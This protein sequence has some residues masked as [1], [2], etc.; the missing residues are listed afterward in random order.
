MNLMILGAGA[1]GCLFGAYLSTSME[2]T[3]VDPNEEKLG[4]LRREGVTVLE[5]GGEETR[6]APRCLTPAEAARER[7]N[8]I[9]VF[10]KSARERRALE[11]IR[12]AMGPE[13]VLMTLQNGMGHEEAML[14][15]APAEQIIIG[16]T[17][18]NAS[19]LSPGVVRHGGGGDT[20]LGVLTGEA[21]RFQPIA[22]LFTA[23]GLETAVSEN[24][25]G[26]IWRKLFLNASGS[27]LTAVYDCPLGAVAEGERWHRCERLIRESVAVAR[28][29]G[30]PFD[31]KEIIAEIHA[32]ILASPEAR[33]SI[34]ADLK[35][36]RRTE[37]DAITGAVVRLGRKYGVPVPE[38]E[39]VVNTIHE[40]EGR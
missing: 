2:V 22:D 16:A 35:A 5:P 14:A 4:L 29:D 12:G 7:G 19:L 40:L 8:L 24:V 38:S 28:A 6:A 1:M 31:E 39:R 21:R 30:Q 17:R 9:L 27:A 34:W 23:A 25:R 33:T 11:A 26:V 13:T 10:V 18:H 15:L 3:L 32:H 20:V 37:V 36:G